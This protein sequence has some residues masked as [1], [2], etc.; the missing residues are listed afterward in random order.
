MPSNEPLPLHPV[1]ATVWLIQAK[2]AHAKLP[3]L[4]PIYG[5]TFVNYAV[6]M[7][8]PDW[9]NIKQALVARLY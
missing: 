8:W 5:T 7:L 1:V 3:C 2:L 4:G 9:E 6:K